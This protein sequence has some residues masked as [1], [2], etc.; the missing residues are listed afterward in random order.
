MKRMKKALAFLL[1]MVMIM[2][3]GMTAFAANGDITINGAIKGATYTA[4]KVFDATYSGN[5]AVA[6]TLKSGSNIDKETGFGDVFTTSSNGGVTYVS[7]KADVSDT[8]VIEWLGNHK[9]AFGDAVVTKT[10]TD[11]ASSI[12]LATGAAG[13]YYIESTLGSK[14]AVTIDTAHPTATVNSKITSEPGSLVKKIN[15]QS[16]NTMEVGATGTFTL[17]FEA[18]NYKVTGGN[19]EAITQY[20]AKDVANGFDLANA[21][22]FAV[23]V[24]GTAYAITGKEVT[25]TVTTATDGTQTMTITIPW[26]QTTYSNPST[27]EITYKAKLTNKNLAAKST[28]TFTVD[29][30]TG[31]SE[32]HTYNYTIEVTKTNDVEKDATVL[33]GAKFV[34]KQGTKFY[35]VDANG[36]VSWV[37]TKAQATEVT[38]DTDG[39]ANFQGLKAGTYTLV[40]TVAPAGYTLAADT[41]ITLDEATAANEA[42]LT[43]TKAVTI[44]DKEGTMLP[45]TGGIGTTIFYV[46]GGILVLGAGVLLVTRR[47]MSK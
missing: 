16:V 46:I 38:T 5:K 15:G 9:S 27:V 6:Y 39:K 19:A 7:K 11:G 47:R 4:Y 29:N 30:V 25:H 42:S 8:K 17:T 1:T 40:E 10:N 21:T 28:N 35:S 24:N 23:K 2:A 34:L 37:D 22:D 36:V 26:D 12:T 20:V 3:L 18:T 41:Q 45:S 14:S 33:S 13:Y 43:L 31:S 32:T 44:K